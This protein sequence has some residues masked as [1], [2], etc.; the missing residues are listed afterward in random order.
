MSPGF[1]DLIGD[2]LFQLNMVLW[3]AQPLPEAAPITPLFHERGFDVYAI[4]PL[5]PIPPDVLLAATDTHLAIQSG[6]RPDVVLVN[7]EESKYAFT[8]CKKSAFGPASSTADQARSLLLLAGPRSHEILGLVPGQVSKALLEY[9]VPE[10]A[11]QPLGLS[12]EVLQRDLRERSFPTGD[13]CV[14]GISL[15]ENNLSLTVDQVG[16]TFFNIAPGQNPFMEREPDTDPRPLYFIPFDPDVEQ[17]KDEKTLC[18]RILFER[19]HSAILAAVG[20]ANP[21]CELTLQCHQILNDATFGMYEHWENKDSA[22]NMRRLCR[23]F[24][25]DLQKSVNSISTDAMTFRSP[26]GWQLSLPD[27]ARHE[28]VIEVL[29]RF[30]S[31][32]LELGLDPKPELFDDL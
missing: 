9:M 29:T 30:C 11:V 26:Q 1:S 18:K 3:L 32:S 22:R 8:E 6:V 21:P 24:V 25:G 16:G 2:P 31:E 15:N 12:L 5:L 19:M 14:F 10:N 28:R 20:H 13:Y 27:Q 23:Q 4:A 7:L 17:S